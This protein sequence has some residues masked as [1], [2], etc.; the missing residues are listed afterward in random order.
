TCTVDLA[1]PNMACAEACPI[2]VRQA[3]GGV[4]GVQSVDVDY[5]AKSATVEAVYP[6]CSRDGFEDMMEK[7]YARGYRA[8]VV[9]AR[10]GFTQPVP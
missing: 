10:S 2:K 1:L 5:D 9:S 8:R 7:L 6:A 3:L 4:A